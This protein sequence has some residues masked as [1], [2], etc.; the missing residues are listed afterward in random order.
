LVAIPRPLTELRVEPSA[1]HGAD[2]ALAALVREWLLELKVMGR[3]ERSIDWYAQKM[4][5]YLASSNATRLSELTA[6]QVKRYL[7]ELRDRALAPNTIHGFFE[8]LRALANW[9]Q[10]ED[11]PVDPALLRLR[12]SQGAREGDG[13][14]QL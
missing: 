3:S 12:R 11:C 10:R 6:L 8:T 1:D 14:L 13:D 4:R 2:V 9:A 7:G 5:W